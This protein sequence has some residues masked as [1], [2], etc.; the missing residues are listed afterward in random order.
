MELSYGL[1]SS[2]ATAHCVKSD[3]SPVESASQSFSRNGWWNLHRGNAAG[4]IEAIC[5][6]QAEFGMPQWVFG[7][8]SYAFESAEKI[9]C[10]YIEKGI[11]NLGMIDTGSGQL[12]P[13]D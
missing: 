11:A 6:T 1:E 4:K 5:E 8:S 7:M 13:V 2:A 9:V 10:T 12:Q 3:A